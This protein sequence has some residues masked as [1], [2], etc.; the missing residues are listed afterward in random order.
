MNMTEHDIS[1]YKDVWVFIE[2]VGGEI[3]PVSWE[4]LGKGRELARD[5]NVRLAG[6]LLGHNIRAHTSEVIHYGADAVFLIDDPVLEHYRTPPY[7]HALVQLAQKYKPEIMLLG[8][9]SMGRDLAGA[10]ATRLGTGL[11]ADCTVLEIDK[12]TRL[13]KQTRPAWGGNIMATILCKK[14]RPQMASVRPRVMAMPTPDPARQGKV[15][16]EALGL[17]EEDVPQKFVSFNPFRQN[18][19][20]GLNLSLIP[21]HYHTGDPTVFPGEFLNYCLGDQGGTG[22]FHLLPHPAV[23]FG[24][25]Y[26]EGIIGL[27]TELIAAVGDTEVG[28]FL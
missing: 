26:S 24:P 20:I 3:A 7:A 2:Q 28:L 13:L 23:K 21:T 15:I 6:V 9:T 10:V 25:E 11:T 18:N 17:R 16:E 8:A 12:E 14:H 4:L 19:H 22:R 27:V 1:A 5:L